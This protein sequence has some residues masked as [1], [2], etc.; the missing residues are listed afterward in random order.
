M[1]ESLIVHSLVVRGS[2]IGTKNFASL[3][4][5]VPMADKIGLK[6]GR[7]SVTILRTLAK[8]Y[9]IPGLEPEGLKPLYCSMEISLLTFPCKKQLTC[10]WKIYFKIGLM[11]IIC[12]KTLSVSYL[13]GI[14]LNH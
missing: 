6:D 3:Y 14:C 1:K 11:L 8:P 7:P 10:V 12:R 13:L 4:V 9:I 5:G 2:S